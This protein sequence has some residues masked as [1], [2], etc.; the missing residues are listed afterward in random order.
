MCQQLTGLFVHQIV[1]YLWALSFLCVFIDFGSIPEEGDTQNR[2]GGTGL[3]TS[4]LF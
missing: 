1:C 2:R 3:Y 4:V